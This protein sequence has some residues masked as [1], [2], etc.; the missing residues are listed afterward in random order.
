MEGIT[1]NNVYNENLI[2]VNYLDLNLVNELEPLILNT[3]KSSIITMHFEEKKCLRYYKIVESTIKIN[4]VDYYKHSKINSVQLFGSDYIDFDIETEITSAKYIDTSNNIIQIIS[5]TFSNNTSY[6]YYRF[7]L[8]TQDN[9]Y[10]YE[11]N[12]I[13]NVVDINNYRFS[14]ALA[15]LD[16]GELKKVNYADLYIED[17]NYIENIV[18]NNNEYMTLKLKFNLLNSHIK[19]TNIIIGNTNIDESYL[20]TQHLIIYNNW[21]TRVF[22]KGYNTIYDYYKLSKTFNERIIDYSTISTLYL[23]GNS[24]VTI[25]HSNYLDVYKKV[26]ST[27]TSITE[28]NSL[29]NIFNV[30][31][32]SYVEGS[33]YITVFTVGTPYYINKNNTT[34]DFELVINILST[35]D[36]NDKSVIIN[37]AFL[38]EGI[39]IVND[40]LSNNIYINNMNGFYIPET[41]I[42]IDDNLEIGMKKTSNI[43][44]P[45]INNNYD[46]ATYNYLDLVF[47]TD[48]EI[49]NSMTYKEKSSGLNIKGYYKDSKWH[50]GSINNKDVYYVN[51]NSITLKGKYM[52]FSGEISN[53]TDNNENIINKTFNGYDVLDIG[54]DENNIKN[55]LKIDLKLEN[56]G[57]NGPENYFGNLDLITEPTLKNKYLVGYSGSIHQKKIYKDVNITGSKYIYLSIDK[58]NNMVNTNKV[59]IFSKIFLNTT[60]GNHIYN[61]FVDSEIVFD[62]MPLEELADLNIKFL[63]EEN[64]LFN[65]E[66]SEHTFTLEITE[67]VSALDNH[68][69]ITQYK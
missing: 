69:I 4:N 65:F 53:K 33:D 5:K 27:I 38:Y 59:N 2:S 13:N 42:T 49:C 68:D 6:K 67:L 8:M 52:G 43:Y 63:T 44:T 46:T 28:T 31:K 48:D 50:D 30:T 51:Y 57:I 3:G 12:N 22:Y 36:A 9:A 17:V 1:V 15:G 14:I 10:P 66:R 39:P 40:Y 47:K 16:V 7:K 32:T 23:Y 37:D 20:A 24:K 19:N 62:E 45:I 55:K 58:L 21:Y 11:N 61:S 34:N 29:V 18:E 64:K 35:T 26:G 41:E 54:Y 25:R 60:P 56:M